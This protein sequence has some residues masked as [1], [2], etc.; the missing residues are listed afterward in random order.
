[1]S[2]DFQ[3]ELD[4]ETDE[5]LKHHPE[6]WSWGATVAEA[7][8]RTPVS[9]WGDRIEMDPDAGQ[10]DLRDFTQDQYDTFKRDY[11]WQQEEHGK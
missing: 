11:E 9:N 10:G 8:R 6:R 1:M 3:R 5:S 7:F 4:E 2:D